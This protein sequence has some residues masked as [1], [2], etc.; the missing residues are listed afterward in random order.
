[1]STMVRFIASSAVAL[2]LTAAS[3]LAAPTDAQVREFLAKIQDKDPSVRCAA[4][5][6]AGPM[7][8]RVV[9]PLGELTASPDPGIAKAAREALKVV[10]HYAARP[11]AEA[12]RKAVSQ[13]L[14]RLLDKQ[15]PVRTRAEAA[16]LLGLVGKAEAIAPLAACLSDPDVREDARMALE[17]IPGKASEKALTQAMA[18]ADP[19]F[20]KALQQSIRHRATSMKSVGTGK[21]P[22]TS[23]GERR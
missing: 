18:K 3:T 19:Q 13:A 22:E 17:R 4:W 15:Y 12:E 20:K 7:G 21:W 14:C 6:N 11:G 1:M 5:Q 23:G 16:Y 9:V 10:A 8:A 2:L